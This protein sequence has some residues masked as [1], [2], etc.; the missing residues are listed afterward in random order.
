MEDV[1][2]SRADSRQRRLRRRERDAQKTA[3][4]WRDAEVLPNLRRSETLPAELQLL[5]YNIT[6]EPVDDRQSSLENSI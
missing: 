5:S 1:A 6:T 3:K 2:M 4:R